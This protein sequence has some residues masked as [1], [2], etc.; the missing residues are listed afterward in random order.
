MKKRIALLFLLAIGA[1]GAGFLLLR[2]QEGENGGAD[3]RR[4]GAGSVPVREF[5]VDTP[6]GII[7][8][9]D[10]YQPFQTDRAEAVLLVHMMNR[11]RKSWS[12]FAEDLAK[13][14]FSVFAIDLRGHGESTKRAINGKI[15]TIDFRRFSNKEHQQSV[16]DILSTLAFMESR[17][18]PP[19][20]VILGGASIGSLLALQA[21]SQVPQIKAVFLLSPGMEYRGIDAEKALDLVPSGMPVFF[22]ASRQDRY[23]FESADML[24]RQARA[25]GMETGISLDTSEG[26]GTDM[27][28]SNP[29]LAEEIIRWI[30]SL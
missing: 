13:R 18:I 27:F 19:R 22:A 2:V 21:A 26:H 30:Y 5:T 25:R 8:A 10:W 20:S 28:L 12:A 7:I 4:G 9:G 3:I 6:D 23:S 29:N 14:G 24:S 17:G 16:Q 11:D 15:E 1:A